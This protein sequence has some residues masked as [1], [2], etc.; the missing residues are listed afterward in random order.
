MHNTGLAAMGRLYEGGDLAAALAQT[1]A[2]TLAIYSHLDL[3]ALRVP[4]LAI[5][6]LPLWELSHIAWFQEYWCLRG[7]D[8]SRPALLP[9]SD[10]LFNSST[11]PHATRWSLDYPGEARLRQYMADTLEATLETLEGGRQEAGGGRTTDRYFFELALRHEDM[12]GEALLMTLQTLSLPAPPIDAP[13]A[14]RAPS[15]APSSDIAFA[16]GTF[17]QGSPPG[18]FVFDNEMGAHEVTV[19]P[20]SMASRPVT[21][22]EFAD[23]L[24]DSG[25]APPAHW[26]RDSGQWLA[27]R[28]DRWM[29][30]ERSFPMVHVSLAQAQ[31]YCDWAGRRLPTE[32]EWEF[33]ATHDSGNALEALSGAVWQWTT[34]PFAP[35][36]G[37]E[38]GPYRDYSQPWFHDHTVLRG[39]SFATQERIA[40]R[41]YRNFYKPERS[42]PFAGLRT[43]AVEAR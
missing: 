1:R 39:G 35:Y 25:G 18:G 19:A 42:D 24:D 29:P 3:A 21:Q 9:D 27:R 20:F 37:F 34:T 10:S 41:R 6:N 30:I 32:S 43:C 28:F 23:Y 31:L 16:G 4:Q 11:V 22:G 26:R 7:G 17:V 2:R 14:P 12:H 5:V 40:T 8:E 13:L 36:P 38:P 15:R 33:A